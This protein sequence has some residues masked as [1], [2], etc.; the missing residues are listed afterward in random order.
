MNEVPVRKH[1]EAHAKAVVDGDFDAVTA[2][3]IDDLKP[4]VPEIGKVL[5]RPVTDA[6]VLKVD[7][8]EDQSTVEIR[9]AGNEG[10]SVTIRSI[11]EDRDGRPMIVAGEPLQD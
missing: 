4:S 2:D 10:E 11:W 7:V 3:F 6:E 1:A 5:P 8:G 9:Y